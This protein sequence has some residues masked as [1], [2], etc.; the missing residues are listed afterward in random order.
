V[1]PLGL[2]ERIRQ[3]RAEQGVTREQL[4]ALARLSVRTVARVESDEVVPRADTLYQLAQALGMKLD[5]LL[6]AAPRRG[7]GTPAS[8]CW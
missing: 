8:G 5:D 1:A 7:R 2:G 6:T 3:A 4:A